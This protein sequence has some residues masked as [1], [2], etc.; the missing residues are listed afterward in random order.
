LCRTN[1]YYLIRGVFNRTDFDHPW[2]FDRCVEVQ[3]SPDNHLDLW[4]REHRKSTII[5]YAL[6]IQDILSSHGEDPLEKWNGIEATVGIFSH[7]RPIAKKFLRQIQMEL[8]T[9]AFL[10]ALFPDILY[11]NPNKD[12]QA[13]SLD[14]GLVVKRKSNSKEA[15]IE[16]HGLVDGQPTGAHF[17]IRVYDD[18]VTRSSVTTPDMIQKTTE[19]WELSDNLGMEGGI[20]RYI[21]TRYHFSDTYKVIMDRNV[22]TPRIHAATEDGTVDGVPVLLS[23]AALDDKRRKQ[24]PYTFASQQLL[25]PLA[26][27]SQGFKREWIK[28][29][30]SETWTNLNLA[31]LVDPANE[32]K[33]RSD[34]TAMWVLGY[35]ADKKW[36]VIDV[37]RDRMNLTERTRQLFEWHRKY[38]PLIVGYEKYGM[39]SDIEHIESEQARVNYQFHIDEL[40]GQLSKVDR[41]RRLIPM[42]ENGDLLMKG[43]VYRT[44]HEGKTEDLINVFIE[45]EYMAF[46]VGEHDDMLDALARIH[47]ISMIEPD[48]AWAADL[49]LNTS[50]II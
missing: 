43:S 47:D 10:K 49:H 8:E 31:I 3:Q 25:N 36:R 18:V 27:A 28:Y 44:N 22:V 29:H 26:D 46:P 39:Q 34:Y 16:A 5:T 23:R 20:E 30:E 17:F 50:H 9:N 6:T 21:G 4:A 11:D 48:S 40:G 12:A 35:G 38:Q 37:L 2:L 7:T 1:L 32:K 41:I 14:A 24:G 33:K 15:T 19:A 13:W 42:F 45:Q